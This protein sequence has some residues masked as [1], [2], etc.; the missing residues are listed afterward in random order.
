MS[1][2]TANSIP[3]DDLLW[4][5]PKGLYICFATELWE[6]FSFYG[7]RFL[8]ILYLTKYHLFTDAT[9]YDVLGS[10]AG[11]VYA[12]PLIGGFLADRYLGMRKAV[13]FGGIMLV[14]GHGLMAFEGTQ[15]SV[16]NGEVIRD[17]FAIN[18]FYLALAFIV[19][20]VGFLKPNISTIVGKLY[21]DNDPRRDSGFTI[22]YQGINLGSFVATL[23][24]TWLGETYG[25]GYGFGAA[26]LGML[27]G[28]V[29]FLWGQKYL[30]GHAEPNDPEVLKQSFLGPVNKEWGIYLMSFI[31]LI[32]VWFLLQKIAIVF[33]TQNMFLLVGLLSLIFYS[34]FYK[35]QQH[36]KTLARIF[37]AVVFLCGILAV[38]AF[39]TDHYPKSIFASVSIFNTLAQYLE[40]ISWTLLG[41]SAGFIIYGFMVTKTEEYSRMIVLIILIISTIIFWALFE[42]ASGSMTLFADRVVDRTLINSDMGNGDAWKFYLIGIVFFVAAA[43][44]FMSANKYRKIH[45]SPMKVMTTPAFVFALPTAVLGVAIWAYSSLEMNWLVNLSYLGVFLLLLIAVIVAVA[46]AFL[47]QSYFYSRGNDNITSTDAAASSASRSILFTALALVG[48][49]S[50]WYGY[51]QFGTLQAGEIK[52]FTIEPTAS[53][54]GSLNA[55][56]IILLAPVFAA[57]W[58][59]LGKRNADP[60][61]P[62][63][64][65]LGLIQAGLGFGALLIGAMFPSEA[66]KVAW[67]WLM[68]AYLLHTTGE[69]CLSPVGLSAVTK[70]SIKNVVSM[71]MGAWF[72]ATALSEVVASQLGKLAALD[73]EELKTLSVVEQ[74]VKYNDLWMK[75]LWLGVGFGLFMLILSPFL[76]KGMKGIH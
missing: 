12:L 10:Y 58:V 23:I 27:L 21:P 36:D 33:F 31:S 63:K 38:F 47:L 32:G 7:M 70:L 40:P 66:G 25:W 55:M 26:G 17:T 24:C 69:L 74:L 67:V 43:L 56:F 59:K 16:V 39:V 51:S 60:S 1:T 18:V 76:K 75:L 5:H 72:L 52:N 13:I 11:L 28:L 22:F 71:V 6:R 4:G 8:L 14:I 20:G 48:I 30:Y 68:L 49:F 54:Y 53:Q 9:G 37:S 15:A 41:L 42:Q 46:F 2:T 35:N 64:F 34:M 57:L 19:V 44:L 73:P 61:V 29:T 65:S 3:E 50:I 45:N 62:V